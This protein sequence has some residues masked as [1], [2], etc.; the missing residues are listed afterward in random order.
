MAIQASKMTVSKGLSEESLEN[1]IAKQESYHEF[2]NWRNSNDAI[3]G[4]KAFSEKR[5]PN[6]TGS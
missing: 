2:I 3:E 1:A 5:K 6:W 4:I